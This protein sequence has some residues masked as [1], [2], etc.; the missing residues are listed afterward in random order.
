VLIWRKKPCR[1][2][3]TKNGGEAKAPGP[4]QSV[5]RRLGRQV[6]DIHSRES[7]QI[8][9][10]NH[11]RFCTYFIHIKGYYSVVDTIV[12]SRAPGYR[13]HTTRR[14]FYF[15]LRL[16]CPTTLFPLHSWMPRLFST[17]VL[18]GVSRSAYFPLDPRYS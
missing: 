2:A 17:V 15:Q 11:S 9:K 14:C 8:L 1:Q 10:N 3:I 13:Y 5:C 16:G 12:T 4:I 18:R 7:S 6:S